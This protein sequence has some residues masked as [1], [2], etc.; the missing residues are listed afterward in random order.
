VCF[1]QKKN[2]I[3]M[4]LKFWITFFIVSTLTIKAQNIP[5]GSIDRV[6]DRLRNEQL[7]GRTDSLVSFALR[8]L[9]QGLISK[10]QV[11]LESKLPNKFLI[12][13]LPIK[14]TQQYNTLAPVGWNDGAMIPA[15]G[16]QALLSAGLYTSYG[17]LSVQ[18]KPE[19]V[20]ADN[21][22]FETFPLTESASVRSA[23]ISYLNMM[24]APERLGL[25]NYNN[26]FWGQS[27]IRLAINK[28]SIGISS[29]NLWWGPGQQNSLI[30]SNNA[31]GFLHFTLNTREPIITGIGSF[32][33][34]LISGKL[35]ASGFDSPD[36]DYIIDG[37]NYKAP[38]LQDWRYLSGVTINYQPKWVPGLF[39]GMNRVFQ[40][41][42]SKMGHDFTDYFPVI[43]PFQKKN[44]NEEDAKERDQLASLFFRWVLKESKFEMYAESGWNDHSSTIWDLFESPE[45]SRSY[46]IGFTKI[47]ILNSNKDNYLKFNFENTQMQ[48]SADR[49]VRPAGAW[50]IHGFVQHGYTQESQVIG[51]GIGPG[52]NSQ[53]LDFSVW[54]KERVW[55]VQLE[56][57][58]HNMDFYYD[59]YTDYNNKWVDLNFNTYAYRRFGHLGVQAKLNTAWMRNYQWQLDNNKLNMQVQVTLEY[60]L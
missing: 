44:L 34:Q 13:F 45:H 19:F 58:A 25:S 26:F 59:A 23:H 31:P 50:Y 51:A 11:N 28:F 57:Y 12:S 2:R 32:E 48:Q 5:V 22:I 42:R 46:L 15:K 35:E 53:T 20:Y 41:Y 49:L 29:E 56:R 60:H 37:V 33:G 1:D 52:G 55:G 7:L 17:L 54:N 24:D 10:S 47:F 30:M 36:E 18:L 4:N 8:P 14:L 6:E 3:N 39:I 40:V 43:S 27:S 16:Y 9:S 38:K 21:P